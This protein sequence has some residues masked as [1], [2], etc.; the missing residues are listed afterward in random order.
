MQ[1]YFEKCYS[2]SN[3]SLR[4]KPVLALLIY[5]YLVKLASFKM[6]YF[7]C[8]SFASHISSVFLIYPTCFKCATC[9]LYLHYQNLLLT[10][11]LKQSLTKNIFMQWYCVIRSY[12]GLYFPTSGKM[13]TRITLNTD[14]F[15]TVDT[16]WDSLFPANNR[17]IWEP[18]SNVYNW[19]LTT[20]SNVDDVF[21]VVKIVNSIQS[22]TI[23]RC[24]AG[25]S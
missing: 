25:S 14:T 20:L 4:D 24:L 9:E 8:T 2:L 16:S 21:F 12:F 7:L 10:D 6:L 3:L 5:R 23:F 13:R 15:H 1:E 17:E 11:S 18:W 19:E 22:F